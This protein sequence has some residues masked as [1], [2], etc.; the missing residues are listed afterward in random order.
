MRR[1]AEGGVDF[2]AP[3]VIEEGLVGLDFVSQELL[4]EVCPLEV[5]RRS[6]TLPDLIPPCEAG[7]L[8]GLFLGLT[9]DSGARWGAFSVRRTL[10]GVITPSGVR[11]KLSWVCFNRPGLCG[12]WFSVSFFVVIVGRASAV[13]REAARLSLVVGLMTGRLSLDVA[14]VPGRDV[15]ADLILALKPEPSSKDRF[16]F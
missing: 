13:V 16:L 4:G 7:T 3:A 11:G 15:S 14:V 9:F 12:V 5:E 2:E 8:R 6:A 1:F 10:F